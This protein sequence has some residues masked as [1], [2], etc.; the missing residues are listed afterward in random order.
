MYADEEQGFVDVIARH[1]GKIV[2]RHTFKGDPLM[3][4][5][6]GEVKIIIVGDTFMPLEIIDGDKS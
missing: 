6:F 2:P 4:R 1:N 5:L 3:H